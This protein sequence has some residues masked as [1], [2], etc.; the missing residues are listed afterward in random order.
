M[1]HKILAALGLKGQQGLMT[2]E[3]YEFMAYITEYGK[4]YATK[5]EY[6]FRA[7]IFKESLNTIKTH[8]ANPEETHTLGLNHLSD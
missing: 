2:P 3:D 4:F 8:N 1:W 7:G 6:K 5:E